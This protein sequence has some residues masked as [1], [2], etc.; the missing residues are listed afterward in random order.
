MTLV[1]VAELRGGQKNCSTSTACYG[2]DMQPKETVSSRLWRFLDFEF[3]S[4]YV[5]RN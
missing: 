4:P 2:E 1:R 3:T 5:Q